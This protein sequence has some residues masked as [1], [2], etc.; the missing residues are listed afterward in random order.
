[1][2]LARPK[3]VLLVHLR[4]I[5][6]PF[7]QKNFGIFLI[8]SIAA[9]KDEPKCPLLSVL[10]GSLMCISLTMMS[11]TESSICSSP[12]PMSLS[13][14]FST[15]SPNTRLSSSSSSSGVRSLRRKRCASNYLMGTA[16]VPFESH[17]LEKCLSPLAPSTS[18]S[19]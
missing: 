15:P 5:R 14:C 18:T 11:L 3:I 12:K 1:M 4:A 19:R 16:R 2:K 9:K 10:A 8:S 6:H 7:G 13:G 17:T